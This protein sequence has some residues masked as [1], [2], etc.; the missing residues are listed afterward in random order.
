MGTLSSTDMD[1]LAQFS[2]EL[3]LS[4]EMETEGSVYEIF[5]LFEF[6]FII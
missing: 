2:H 1:Q 6:E 4:T 3:H 5:I